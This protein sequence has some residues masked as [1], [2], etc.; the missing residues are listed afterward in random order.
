MKSEVILLVAVFAL[1]LAF[2]CIGGGNAENQTNTGAGYT[3]KVNPKT[4]ISEGVVTVE[5]RLKNNFDNDMKD[6]SV[7]IKDLPGF[8]EPEEYSGFTI[9]KGQEY[10]IV[11]SLDVPKTD[12]KQTVNPKIEVCFEYTTNFYFDTALVPKNLATEE[13]QTQ[14][15]YS[16]GPVTISP[17]GLDKLFLTGSKSYI[18]G[19]LDIKN[20]WIGKIKSIESIKLTPG[21]QLSS[22]IKYADCSGTTS[23]SGSGCE[24]LQKSIAIGDGLITT[25]KLTTS[26]S[27]DTIKTSRTNGEV[28][29]NYCYDI[30]MGT[31]T[32][33]PVGQRC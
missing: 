24:T 13:V 10:P 32:I 9:V 28:T 14:S 25:V 30:D 15:S 21:D 19:S 20:N 29:Y 12:L 17:I 26:Y 7:R 11:W 5:L 18:T 1:A 23:L 16:S 8:K 4:V 6:V 27:G 2:G 31:I 22:E 3:L 33:C